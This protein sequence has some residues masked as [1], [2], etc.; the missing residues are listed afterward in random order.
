MSCGQLPDDEVFNEITNRDEKELR[1]QL[2]R[3]LPYWLAFDQLS[4]VGLGGKRLRL[5]FEHFLSIEAAWS[6][7]ATELRTLPWLKSE[8]IEQ[9]VQKRKEVN[10]DQLMETLE[11]T[12]VTALPLNHPLYPSR[13]REI[14]D[15]PIVLYMK[16]QLTPQELDHSIAIVGTR[17]PTTYGQRLAKEFARGLAEAGATV[18]SGM[19]VGVDSLC[20]WGAIEGGGRTVAVLASGPDLCY[21]TSNKP[22]YNGLIDGTHGAVLSEFFPG[23]KPEHWRFPAR[24]RIISGLSKGVVV[25]EAGATSGS[26][27]TADIGFEQSREIFAIPGRVDAPMS[28]G[29]NKL[30]AANKAQLVM[31]YIDVLNALNWV[32]VPAPREVPT[33][34]ELFGREKEVFELVTSEPVHFDVLSQ[35]LEMSAGELSATLTMLEL[36]GI[37]ERLPGDWYA[38]Q[39]K[40]STI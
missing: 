18:V 20:H 1:K 39:T 21:P 38:R 28:M 14:A 26:L 7:S 25:I 9:I 5:L 40:V 23:T 2:T 10:F 22:L 31:N 30:I 16:G 35:R 33:M 4:G 6:A 29:C 34:V 3:E 8:Q 36:A 11:K 17:R 37:V 24:N 19:A 27:I 32:S 15:P 12:G 13:L